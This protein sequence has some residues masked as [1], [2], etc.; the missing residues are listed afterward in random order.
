MFFSQHQMVVVD[1]VARIAAIDRSK[2]IPGGRGDILSSVYEQD[3]VTVDAGLA[4]TALVGNNLKA[5]LEALEKKMRDV[6][7][8]TSG[9][10][11]VDA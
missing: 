11:G 7:A 8:S 10:T 5:H 1:A 6:I 4:D 2:I 9:I 3:H